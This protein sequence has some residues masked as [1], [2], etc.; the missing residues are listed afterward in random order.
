MAQLRRHPR[1]IYQKIADDPEQ[2]GRL[3]ASLP[4]L[5]PFSGQSYAGLIPVLDW[6]HRLPSQVAL[7]RIY[8]FY[9]H[10]R[11]TDAQGELDRRQAAIEARDTYPEFDVPDYGRVLADEEYEADVDPARGEIVRVRLI[12]GWRRDIDPQLARGAVKT[13]KRSDVFKKLKKETASRAD[14]LGDLEAVSWT[15]PCESDYDRWTI[16]C[17]YLL[18]LD[19][20]VGKGRSFL[21]DVEKKTVVAARDFV[22]RTG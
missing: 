13:V 17:W 15:P 19:A 20:A 14:S 5:A 7:L 22:V 4:F 21:V 12:S 10:D 8:A 2:R 9:T 1:V 16:D 18:Y 6:D 11:H 3:R